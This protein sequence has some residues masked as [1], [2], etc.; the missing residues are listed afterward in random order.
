MFTKIRLKNFYSFED[1]TFDLSKGPKDFKHLAI[2]YGEN[3]SGKT[4]LMSGLGVFIDLMRTM[5]VR[6]MIEKILYEQEHPKGTDHPLPKLLPQMLARM[7]RSSENLFKECRMVGN[8]NPVYLEYDFMI[9]EKQGSYIVEFGA[10][11]I[12]HERLEYVLEKRRGIYF[13]LTDG[14]KVINK[15]LFKSDSL[16]RD[17]DEQ[18]KRFWGKHT[19]LAIFLHETNDKSRQYIREGVLENFLELVN[20]FFKVSCYINSNNNPHALIS[21]PTKGG[22]LIDIESGSVKKND[23]KKIDC[24]A[25]SLTYL[26]RSINGDNQRLYYKKE[27]GDSDHINYT[28]YIQKRISGVVRDL[29]FEYESYGNHQIIRMLPLLLRA[30]KGETVVMDESDTGIHDL[31]YAK[32]ISEAKPYLKGQLII[33]THNTL[34]LELDNIKEAIYIIQEDQNANRSVVPVSNAGD[35]IYQQTSLRNK[36]L[37]GAYGGIPQIEAIDFPTVLRNLD[38]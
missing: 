7:F 18:V 2:I 34:L 30:L 31:L 27:S 8:E 33:T 19:F 29:P 1:V 37:C 6:D 17:I 9:N 4:N 12:I 14:K 20:S 28:L 10:D 11:G 15:A 24:T 38:K 35:R 26:F 3:G 5:D 21:G 13:D 16:K 32:I 23:E 36:Y 22:M 25:E